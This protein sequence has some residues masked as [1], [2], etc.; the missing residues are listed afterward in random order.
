MKSW[1]LAL[2]YGF[3]LWLIP[4]AVS[5]VVFPLKDSNPAFFETIMPLVLAVCVVFFAVLYFRKVQAKFVKEAVLVGVIWLA[6]SLIID[7]CMFME[8]PMKMTFAKYMMD[9]GLTYLMYPIVCVGF[10]LLLEKSK[11]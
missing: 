10:G 4:F 11:G 8:G 2:L 7:L 6:I 9:I 5:F 3:L 1:K